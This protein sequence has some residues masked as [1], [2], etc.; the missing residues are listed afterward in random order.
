M[1]FTVR[2][3]S[4]EDID[5]LAAI[6]CAAYTPEKTGE[7]W[8]VEKAKD[9]VQYWYDRSPDDLKILAT[10]K[11]TS[12][13]LGAFFADVKPWWDGVRLIDGEFFILP[14]RQGQGI[15]S[16][17]MKEMLNRA[18]NNHNAKNFETITFMPENGHPLKWYLKIGFEKE[19]DL[20]VIN[21]QIDKIL[22]NFES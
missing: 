15:G 9:I 18:Q 22:K 21:G 11:N 8:T 7:H 5:Q 1:S 19:N 14:D 16:A 12:E 2:N 20:V 13:I 4:V 3:V 17:L 10:D 6:F